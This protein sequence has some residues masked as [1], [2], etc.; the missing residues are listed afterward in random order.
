MNLLIVEDSI[1]LCTSLAQRF[2]EGGYEVR[3]AATLKTAEQVLKGFWPDFVLL[4]ANFPTISGTAEFNA[5]LFLDLLHNPDREPPTVLLMSG[6]DRTASHFTKIRAWLNTGRIADVLPK[7]V[8]GGWEFFKE[9]LMHRIELLRPQRLSPDLFGGR[10]REWF[11]GDRFI[12][13][14][15]TMLSIA[16]QIRHIVHRTD[17][18]RSILLWGANGTG[19]GLIAQWIHAEMVKKAKRELPYVIRGCGSLTGEMSPSELLGS[20]KGSFTSSFAS[21]EGDLEQAGEGVYVLDDFHRL[22]PGIQAVLY[23]ALEERTFRRLGGSKALEFRARLVSTT[24]VGLEELTS[25]GVMPDE[26]YNRIGSYTIVLPSLS[27][28]PRD[29]EPLMRGFLRVGR[30]GFLGGPRDFDLEVIRAFKGYSWPGNI[31][32]LSNIVD[33]LRVNLSGT[34][35]TLPDL[36]KLGITYKGR[37][38]Q[39]DA[40]P[41]AQRDQDSLLA[42]FGWNEGWHKLNDEHMSTVAAWL[43]DLFG[44]NGALVDSLCHALEGQSKP[45]PIHFIK[46]LLFLAANEANRA[47]YKEM[48]EVLDLGWDYTNRVML[49]LAGREVDKVAGF[50]P[51]FLER[52]S[53]SAR[54]VYRLRSDLLLRG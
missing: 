41:P 20:E 39:W 8:E 42:R 53:S 51:P 38:I 44:P 5:P 2:A 45:R 52:D 15:E 54:H 12:S 24:N 48:E 16:E 28:R 32:Q 3:S 4:D 10:D 7:N 43:K 35:V 34:V 46:A 37:R 21:K 22:Q 25:Q 14:E 29:I 13:R 50:Q 23:Q 18:N 49:F 9:L 31:R 40:T 47:S 1:N 27:Q 11:F 26:F 33:N 6:D 36:D 19:K 17:N 30:G